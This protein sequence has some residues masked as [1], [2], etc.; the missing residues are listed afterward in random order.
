MRYERKMYLLEDTPDNR[1]HIGKYIEG[2]QFP[3]GRIEIRVAGV[4]LPYWTYN[5]IGTIDHGVK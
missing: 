4:S 2:F 1:R 5:K 3:D